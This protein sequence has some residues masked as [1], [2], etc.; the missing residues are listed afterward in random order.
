MLAH[1]I[2]I[3]DTM[4]GVRAGMLRKNLRLDISSAAGKGFGAPVG[5]I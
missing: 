1:M 3:K 5:T 2:P 4:P